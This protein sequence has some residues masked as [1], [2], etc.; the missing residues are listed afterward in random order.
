MAWLAA[1]NLAL[2]DI[3]HAVRVAVT[4]SPAGPA[5]FDSLSVLGRETTLYRL[6][7]AFARVA[8]VATS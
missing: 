5:L 8:T 6:E 4:G 3:V 7:A 1:R 2:G